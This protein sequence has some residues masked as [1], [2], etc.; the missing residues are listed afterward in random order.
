MTPDDAKKQGF[1]LIGGA[2]ATP[3]QPSPAAE[4]LDILSTKVTETEIG[5]RLQDQMRKAFGYV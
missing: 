5:S 3:K 4:A 2:A 1:V